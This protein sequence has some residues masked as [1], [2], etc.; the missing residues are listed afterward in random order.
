MNRRQLAIALG[1]AFAALPGAPGKVLA[2]LTGPWRWTRRPSITIIAV[3]GDRRI[4][5]A[6]EAVEY[7]N[8]TFSDLGTPFRLGAVTVVNGIVPGADLQ[9]L[10]DQVLNHAWRSDLPGSITR[11]PGDLLIALSDASFISFTAYGDERAVV[12]IKNPDLPPLTLPN[13]THNV[14]AHELGHAIG[15]RHNADPSLLM[16]GRPAPFRPDAFQSTTEHFF[17][18]SAAE[19]ARLLALYPLD[20]KAR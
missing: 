13:V 2:A 14:I 1:L 7:W 17:P 6:Q 19:N 12:G 10:S 4:P 8:Q 20:W 11:F 18:L 9:A 16:C 3:A 15:L 5:L